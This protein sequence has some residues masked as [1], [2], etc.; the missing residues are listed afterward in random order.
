MHVVPID[1]DDPGWLDDP[2]L[3]GYGIVRDPELVRTSDAFLAEGRLVVRDLLSS[4]ILR[5]RSVLA[6]RTAL[7]WLEREVGAA[8]HEPPVYVVPPDAVRALSGHRFHQG[9][10]A[11]ADRPPAQH[12]GALLDAVAPACVLGLDGVTNPDNVGAIFRT[13]CAFGVEAVLLSPDS[14]SPLYRKAL[15]TS[16]GAAIRLPFS[17][18]PAWGDA[19]SALR[20]RSFEIVALVPDRQANSVE[21][22]REALDPAARIALLLGAEGDGL[23]AASLGGADHSV[24]IPMVS[25][26]DSLN[27]AA[28]AAV[29]LYRL[30]PLSRV[31]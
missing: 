2:R 28:A 9:C 29:A 10:L 6:T 11:I 12:A 4:P 25:G 7:A 27:V 31:V 26:F 21:T 24:R 13:A 8:T 22:L 23:G 15:R 14:V 5:A 19:L 17:H 16:M 18:G 1:T 3:A 20:E 30:G